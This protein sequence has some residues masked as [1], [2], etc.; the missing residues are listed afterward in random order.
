M[1]NDYYENE[2]CTYW[3][4]EYGIMNEIFKDNFERLTL[5]IAQ[6][7]LRG[8]KKV[9][10][11]KKKCIYLELGSLIKMNKSAYKLLW[12]GDAINNVL[13]IGILVEDEIERLAASIIKN[14]STKKRGLKL[15]TEYFTDKETVMFWLIHH[16][17]AS[18]N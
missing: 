9:M 6:E 4:D 5:E 15:P 7:I 18:R 3:F 16:R 10:Q 17:T 11:N 1:K 14:F 13:A 8:R 2:Y 12:S